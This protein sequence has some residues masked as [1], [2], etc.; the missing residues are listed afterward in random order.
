M[1]QVQ[2]ARAVVIA[3]QEYTDWRAGQT[4]MNVLRDCRYDVYQQ[5]VTTDSDCF[6]DDKKIPATWERI[7]TLWG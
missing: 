6:Y 3:N 7:I 5:I 2:F 1:T 4:L